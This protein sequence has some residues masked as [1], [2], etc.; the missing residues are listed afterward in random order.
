MLSELSPVMSPVFP[1]DIQ[2]GIPKDAT[3]LAKSSSFQVYIQLA[4]PIIFLQGFS[5]SHWEGKP[6]A[7]LRGSLIL[8]VTKPTKLKSINLTFK[9]T[10]KTEWPE[11]IP[12]KKQEFVEINDVVKHTWPFFQN[13]LQTV[14]NNQS[15]DHADLLKGSNASLFRPLDERMD[16]HMGGK[17]G[18]AQGRSLSPIGQFL[19]T[20]SKDLPN[21]KS[22][23][24]TFSDMLS[25]SNS[26]SD[27]ASI[28]SSNT[29]TAGSSDPFIFHPGDY[30]YSFEHAIP[31]SYPETISA[32]FGQ[33]EYFLLV[34]IERQ[35]TFKSDVNAKLPI[36]IVRTP[37]DNSV[38]ETEPIAISRDWNTHLHYDIVIVSKD[39]VL[40]AFLPIAFRVTPMDKVALHRIRIF[41][42]ETL[43][44][45]CKGKKV[46]RL[47]PTK[48][49]LL[50]EHRAPPIKDIPPDAAPTKAKY[51]GNLLEDEHGDL[52][53]KEFEYQ[54][55]FPERL[56]FQQ[57]IHPDTSYATIKSNHWIKLS[58]RLS[59]NVDGVKKH[60]E[61]SIDSP[62]HV[63]NKLSSHANTL[64]PS[65]DTHGFIPNS[66][67]ASFGDS[68]FNMYHDSN[69]YF[70]KQVLNSPVMSPEV[71]PLDEKIGLSPRS[72]SPV[73]HNRTSLSLLQQR[74]AGHSELSITEQSLRDKVLQSPELSSNIYQPEHIHSE[75]ASPQA[76]PLSPISSPTWKPLTLIQNQT[77]D[78][79]S[80]DDE[81]PPFHEALKDSNSLPINPPTYNESESTDGKAKRQE[82]SIDPASIHVPEISLSSTEDLG[83]EDIAEAFHFN[84]NENGSL[85]LPVA[86]MKSHSQD[87]R[88]PASR[89]SS[90]SARRRSS[91]ILPDTLP[92]TIKNS[93]ESYNDLEHV[94]LAAGNAESNDGDDIFSHSSAETV[95]NLELTQSHTNSISNQP[96]LLRQVTTEDDTE[97]KA[98]VDLSA[99]VGRERTSWHPLQSEPSVSPLLSQS[100]SMNVL[101]S[102]HALEDFKH[103]LERYNQRESLEPSD[104]TD[105][106]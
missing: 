19:R 45:Y 60:F 75:L 16:R 86:I 76:I 102:N 91:V 2:L 62:I 78:A 17:L 71:Q 94:L 52:I 25:I 29:S 106:S 70:P 34:N 81:L 100:Y 105:S 13:D 83:D 10:S 80:L 6:P 20:S 66:S 35:G 7:I 84:G 65:Y 47:E 41:L 101:Q 44:Y 21:V 93:S 97:S 12:P 31:L 50:T 77:I 54:V 51:L 8:R 24:E 74:V 30:I 89:K 42:T 22:V 61:I 39:I 98:S 88:S 68:G 67:S 3:P 95:Q 63:L 15:T 5:A 58:L 43:E 46:H 104:I 36:T 38:E 69:L 103:N 56:N 73:S 85:N 14:Q 1:S 9:G 57:K 28:K 32:T 33:V 27:M 79:V 64:L 26:V 18:N 23:S 49:F 37:S 72:L 92:S 96:L 90:V 48:K 82:S 53:S 55:F 59:K 11:G 99:M 4:E 87:E 40:D